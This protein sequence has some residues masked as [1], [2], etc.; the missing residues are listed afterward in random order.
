MLATAAPSSQD[1]L[2]LLSE[3]TRRQD[4][5]EDF[6]TAEDVDGE[7][8]D[9][10]RKKVLG[11]VLHRLF[12][13]AVPLDDVGEDDRAE[14]GQGEEQA[15]DAQYEEGRHEV[16]HSP[17][18]Y[19]VALAP[20][21]V[22][23]AVAVVAVPMADEGPEHRY[24]ADG[25]VDRRKDLGDGHLKDGPDL[26]LEELA[27]LVSVLGEGAADVRCVLDEGLA[28]QFVSPEVVDVYA[29]EENRQEHD[30]G[31]RTGHRTPLGHAVD[32]NTGDLR[33]AQHKFTFRSKI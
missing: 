4:V 13:P 7:I 33:I 21:P 10:G 6:A 16:L 2:T 19:K 30:D 29:D 15:E 18:I 31:L 27:L 9:G 22:R 24:D 32:H 11:R 20:H 28:D 12:D 14:L 26:E 1:H 25:D 3:S 23:E 5:D 8:A 17:R